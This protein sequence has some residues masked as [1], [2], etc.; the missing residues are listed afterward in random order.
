MANPTICGNA[1]RSRPPNKRLHLTEGAAS[2]LDWR[3]PE[4]KMFVSSI[5]YS[6]AEY[7]CGESHVVPPQVKRGR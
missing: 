7:P 2:E 6:S 3:L 4:F 1:R 5:I